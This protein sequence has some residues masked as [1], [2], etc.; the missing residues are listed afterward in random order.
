MTKSERGGVAIVHQLFDAIEGGDATRLR[1]LTTSQCTMWHNYSDVETAFADMIPKLAAFRDSLAE[2]QYAERTYVATLDGA[3]GTHR[4]CA[5]SHSGV[6][7]RIPVAVRVTIESNRIRHIAEYLD[8]A[9][10][11]PLMQPPQD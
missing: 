2:L 11:A 1:T 9:A 10:L 7:V 6:K 3:I 5:S 8:P 4:L